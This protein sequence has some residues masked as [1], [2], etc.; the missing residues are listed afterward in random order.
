MSDSDAKLLV[1]FLME[2]H[3]FLVLSI[4]LKENYVYLVYW[5]L[6]LLLLKK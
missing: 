1:D 5:M 6:Q 3:M 4:S 2:N